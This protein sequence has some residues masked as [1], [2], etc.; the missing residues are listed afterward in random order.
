MSKR[1]IWFLGFAILVINFGLEWYGYFFARAQDPD[2]QF[3][4]R[5]YWEAATLSWLVPSRELGIEAHRR[6]SIVA[7]AMA[8]AWLVVG[9]PIG[10]LLETVASAAAV[11]APWLGG[12]VVLASL[13]GLVLVARAAVRIG[14]PGRVEGSA[15]ATGDIRR[16]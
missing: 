16:R 10:A 7:L 9:V 12:V 11:N 13:V 8:G 6:G 4:G 2:R 1:L 5:P 15:S 3:S 14:R